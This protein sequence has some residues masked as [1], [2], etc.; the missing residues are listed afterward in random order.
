[1]GLC[2]VFVC[3]V[4][5]VLCSALCSAFRVLCSV[6]CVLC[7]QL[8]VTPRPFECSEYTPGTAPSPLS[9]LKATDPKCKPQTFM[10]PPNAAV[11]MTNTNTKTKTKTKTKPQIQNVS[12]KH[13]CVLPS[14][15]C[16]LHDK[17]K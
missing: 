11:Y 13:S 4:F 8:Y 15:R 5:C 3:S 17:Y 10:R 9:L 6:F 7:Q 1:M 16:C 14:R 12:R 2:A